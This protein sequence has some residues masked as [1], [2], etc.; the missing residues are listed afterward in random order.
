MCLLSVLI[1]PVD[2]CGCAGSSCDRLRLLLYACRLHH[3]TNLHVLLLLADGDG[4]GSS[5]SNI[6]PPPVNNPM[7][8]VKR[9]LGMQ[10]NRLD[11]AIRDRVEAAIARLG[12]RVTV[13]QVSSSGGGVAVLSAGVL[14]SR[15]RHSDICDAVFGLVLATQQQ[16]QR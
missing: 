7:E 6:N 13:G 1:S 16:Q 3:I 10:S 5:G 11:Q 2:C 4:W 8:A 12:Y 15:H 14:C 9:E